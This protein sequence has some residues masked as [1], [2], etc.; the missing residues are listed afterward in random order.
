MKRIGPDYFTHY[1]S[2]TLAFMIRDYWAGRGHD[3]RAERFE[4]ASGV[5]GIRSDMVNGLPR[6]LSGRVA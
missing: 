4:I 2:G 1:G 5:F 6:P 3:V